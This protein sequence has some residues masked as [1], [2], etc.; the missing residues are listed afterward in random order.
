MWLN[1]TGSGNETAAHIREP[2]RMAFM[3]SVFSGPFVTLRL[4]GTEDCLQPGDVGWDEGLACFPDL[5]APRQIFDLA[6]DRVQMSCGSG[7][8]EMRVIRYLAEL[9]SVSFVKK[10]QMSGT[11]PIRRKRT[12]SQ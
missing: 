12:W 7:V 6:I 11:M 8:P 3:F 5:P 4:Y 1:I 2:P 9:E 10:C